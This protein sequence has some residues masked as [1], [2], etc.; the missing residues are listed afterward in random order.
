MI[1]H[2]I[3]NYLAPYIHTLH[4]YKQLA[5]ATCMYIDVRLIYSINLA[6]GYNVLNYRRQK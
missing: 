1:V 5:I 3:Y 2:H 4:Y 6:Y